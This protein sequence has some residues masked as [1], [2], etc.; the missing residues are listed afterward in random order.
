MF[1]RMDRRPQVWCLSRSRRNRN[2]P[3]VMLQHT[4]HRHTRYL[5][6]STAFSV[7]FYMLSWLYRPHYNTFCERP[8]ILSTILFP[9]H[10]VPDPHARFIYHQSYL[11]SDT[12]TWMVFG[13]QAI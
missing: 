1:R 3:D 2:T 12:T 6:F 9:S 11:S 8:E 4:S 13:T 7:H 10:F 5:L